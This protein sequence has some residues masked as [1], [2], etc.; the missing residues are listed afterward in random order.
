MLVQDKKTWTDYKALRQVLRCL[1]KL[2]TDHAYIHHIL[3]Q[4]TEKA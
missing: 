4:D 3:L 1:A 2:P